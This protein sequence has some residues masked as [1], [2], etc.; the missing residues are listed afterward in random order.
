[1]NY[2]F[3]KRV[4]K[5]FT[6]NSLL[7]QSCFLIL[8]L[9]L[10]SC[11]SPKEVLPSRDFKHVEHDGNGTPIV[12]GE[13]Y[14]QGIKDGEWRFFD[15]QGRVTKI[16][17]Y[18]DNILEGMAVYYKHFESQQSIKEEGLLVA[19]KR[20]GLWV[21]YKQD[22]RKGWVRTMHNVYD[23][24]EK[25]ISKTLFHRNGQIKLE[26]FMGGKIEEWYYRKYNDKGVLIFE[27]K[28]T[29]G[30]ILNGG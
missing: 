22:T 28:E 9:N 27:G 2:F 24:K 21:A 13:H 7:F 25:I 5:I 14:K 20:T 19:G 23:E 16:E 30:K 8:L 1:M 11:H 18:K 4:F 26:V 6:W 29:V 12:K 10:F 15:R 17:Q 3:Q